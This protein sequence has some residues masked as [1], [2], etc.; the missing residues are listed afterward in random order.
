MKFGIEVYVDYTCYY[1]EQQ[2]R[3]VTNDDVSVASEQNKRTNA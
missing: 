3:A 1:N 2:K